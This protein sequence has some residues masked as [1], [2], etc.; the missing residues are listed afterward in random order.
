V[1]EDA[2]VERLFLPFVALDQIAEAATS[3]DA[4]P[5]SLVEI[6]TAGEQL[7]ITPAIASFFARLRAAS[8]SGCRLVNHYGPSEAHLVTTHALT[9]DPA[10]WD[11]L[12]SIGRPISNA[13]VHLLDDEGRPVPIGAPGEIYVGGE[14]LARGY[15]GR[16]DLTAERFVPS[17]LRDEPGARLYRTGDLARFAP[18]GTLVFLG[19]R[20]LQ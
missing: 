6:D 19:R 16:P 18:D 20:D 11:A 8:R 10:V 3:E 12:P 4:V 13:A 5:T 15:H 7:R 9:G 14:G 2:R 1:V 17:P